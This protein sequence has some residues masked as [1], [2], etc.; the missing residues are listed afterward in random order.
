M[1]GLTFYRALSGGEAPDP[2]E[3]EDLSDRQTTDG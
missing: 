1:N 3:G 2:P